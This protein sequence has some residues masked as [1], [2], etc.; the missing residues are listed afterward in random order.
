MPIT[1]INKSISVRSNAI[2]SDQNF[3]QR[4]LL[5]KYNGKKVNIRKLCPIKLIEL[6]KIFTIICSFCPITSSLI[7]LI[8][9]PV[10]RIIDTTNYLFLCT[11]KDISYINE[12]FV[13][14]DYG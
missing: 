12:R 2:L 9:D 11:F 4:I 14:I 3:C 1:M 5:P 6:N 10:N 8:N 7:G 13:R